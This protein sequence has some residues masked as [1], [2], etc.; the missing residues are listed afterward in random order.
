MYKDSRFSTSMR[1]VEII[2]GFIPTV[3]PEV[4][5]LSKSLGLTIKGIEYVHE[6]KGY[7]QSEKN[8]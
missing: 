3:P 6:S 2:K 8:I 5:A 1:Q 7:G 4:L